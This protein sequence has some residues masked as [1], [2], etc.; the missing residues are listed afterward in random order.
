[1]NDVVTLGFGEAQNLAEGALTAAGADAAMAASLARATM[2][3]ERR[4]KPAVGFAHLVDYLDSLVAGRINGKAAPKRN[5]PAPALISM[6]ADGGIAQ[7]CFDLAIDDLCRK[8]ENFGIT[9][10]SVSNSY[11]TGELGDY[12]S[13][14]AERGLV[15]FAATNGPP[16]IT[17]SG[18]TKPVYCTN[19]LAFAA[20]RA[21]GP[22]LLIDQSSSATAF[23]NIRNAAAE[24]TAIPQGW[25]VDASGQP[26][27]DAK[28]ALKGA[29]LAFGGARGANI[30]LMIE[31]LAA[32]LSGA[33][34]SL[35]APDFMTGSKTPGCGLLVIAI[36]PNLLDPRFEERL[37]G[38]LDRLENQYGV[39]IPGK[40]KVDASAGPETQGI[41]LPSALLRRISAFTGH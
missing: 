36:A 19:P 24:G 8:A 28:A 5:D 13:R 4:G 11:T 32:G 26:T 16:L 34:W 9:L 31:V 18:G 37:G 20:P 39:H 10:L 15:A 21:D 33:N 6:D 14:L 38:Q 40:P 7:F 25:A 29:M 35:D 12:A 17:G 2:A 23:V 30:A 1:M 27:T 41:H 22:P 3:A